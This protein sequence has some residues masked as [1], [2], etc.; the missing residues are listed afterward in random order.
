[1]TPHFCIVKDDPERGSYGDCL[2]ACVASI[3]D[4]HD[5]RDVPH[6]FWD[7]CEAPIGHERLINYLAERDSPLMPF[8]M[9]VSGELSVQ[10]VLNVIGAGVNEDACYILVGRVDDL[11]NNHAVVCRGTEIVHDPSWT[12]GAIDLPPDDSDWQVIFLIHKSA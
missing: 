8:Y 10:D 4:I 5:I 2:R 12:P 7:N 1:M 3:L 11:S 6:F 9:G